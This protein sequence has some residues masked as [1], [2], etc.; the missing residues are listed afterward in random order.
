MFAALSQ[1]AGQSVDF[2]TKKALLVINCQ[3]DAF[4][5]LDDFHITENLEF[6]KPLR[7]LIPLFRRL[8][9]VIWVR[10]EMGVVPSTPSPDAE[11]IE[12]ESSELVEENR[13]TQNHQEAQIHDDTN[14]QRVR[15]A[16][17]QQVD[18]SGSGPVPVYDPSSRIKRVM[19][20][21]S[22]DVRTEVRSSNLQTLDDEDGTL[23][24]RL[25]KPRKGQQSRF[26]VGGTRGAE[27]CDELKDLVDEDDLVVTKHFYSAFDQTELLTT[28]RAELITEVYLCGAL[29]NASV[30]STAADAVQHGLEVAVIEDC[31]G[32]RSRDKHEEALHQMSDIMG[33][34]QITSD[35]AIEESG[36]RPIPD[37]DTPGITVKELNLDDDARKAQ[38]ALLKDS[39]ARPKT[40]SERGPSIEPPDSPTTPSSATIN[41][42]LR[43]QRARQR[44]ALMMGPG[45]AIGSGD[46]KVI[47]DWLDSSLADKVFHQLKKE[48][49]WQTMD[50]RGGQVPRLVAVQGIVSKDGSVPIYR[51]PADESPP[52]L[53]FSPTVTRIRQ[54]LADLLEQPFNHVLIQLYRNGEDN[55]SEH[56]DK[57]LD[58]VRHSD[59]VNVSF[60][61]QRAMTLRTKRMRTSG[62]DSASAR[63]VQKVPLP[64]NSVF[65]LGSKSNRE[66]LHGV[67]ADKRPV[68]E[69]TDDEKAYGG[70]RISL[71]FRHI[72]TYLNEKEQRIWGSG[73]RG[74]S[75]SKA[76]HVSNDDS[77]QM[78][79]MVIAFG[80][81]NHKS[82]FDWDAEY[83]TGFDVVNLVTKKLPAKLVLSSDEV[84][85]LRVQL[86]LE[87]HSIP[88]DTV[89][90]HLSPEPLHEKPW[91]H[92]LANTS[93]P[94]LSG[95]ILGV[96]P[97]DG[98]L[99]ILINLER[100]Y[101]QSETDGHDFTQAQLFS[102][103]AQANE[104]LY[105]WYELRASMER[106][107]TSSPT[108]RFNIENNRPP[109]PEVGLRK[110][111]YQTLKGWEDYLAE[112]KYPFIAGDFWSIMDCAFWPVFNSIVIG[113]TLDSK[114]YPKLLDYHRRAL[115]RESVKK[116]V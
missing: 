90:R 79:A 31:L 98:D 4:Y 63:N 69:K 16:S 66:W 39:S 116:H 85:N 70:E 1:I 114:V 6:L 41:Q 99:A 9:D 53:E 33:V 12:K 89:D 106:S 105:L 47:H 46:S 111:L 107:R 35:E 8:G 62:L 7:E 40:Q 25:V 110:E 60:G 115:T 34:T 93:S 77:V 49:E 45:D 97:V 37:S 67:R 51:H 56:S 58:I 5:R 38:E 27:I 74:K 112:V 17:I 88:Y 94:V 54:K 72:G 71:T 30:Y 42:Q 76:G 113:E 43:P 65:V 95:L 13:K 104:L 24:D 59:I 32:W 91:I 100:K 101:R 80:K 50:H 23:Q 96:G 103:I 73:A 18:P 55:I 92:G 21:A 84:I 108:Y 52:L 22:P 2:E 102:C 28:L 19:T 68:Q 44:F 86:S 11:K 83:G 78:E 10:T 109:S 29:T 81:E 3:N 64:H 82:D 14:S 61:A 26:F 75:K 57:T 36:G 87:E 15:R 48:V 20:H